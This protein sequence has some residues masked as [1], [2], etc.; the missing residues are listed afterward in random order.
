LPTRGKL[1]DL[2][3]D[4]GVRVMELRL[5]RMLSWQEEAFSEI[6][7]HFA[8]CSREA[9]ADDL[10]QVASAICRRDLQRAVSRLLPEDSKS[11]LDENG[12]ELLRRVRQAGNHLRLMSNAAFELTTIEAHEEQLECLDMA[13]LLTLYDR[14]LRFAVRRSASESQRILPEYAVCLGISRFS[15]RSC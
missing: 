13:S 4:S 12:V 11:K 2:D 14:R 3:L 6:E 10:P 1:H 15:S 5:G 8:A 7:T 9:Q